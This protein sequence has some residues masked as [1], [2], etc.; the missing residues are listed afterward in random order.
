MYGRPFGPEDFDY[1][2][3]MQRIKQ[4]MHVRMQEYRD[5]ARIAKGLPTEAEEAANDVSNLLGRP[6]LCSIFMSSRSSRKNI[7]YVLDELELRKYT[8]TFIRT[9]SIRI[10]RSNK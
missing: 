3:E 10:Y 6:Q 2:K 7:Y 9:V 8:F 1:R 5:A 4:W